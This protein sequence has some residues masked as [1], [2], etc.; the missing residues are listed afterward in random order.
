MQGQKLL[1]LHWHSFSRS[2]REHVTVS[3]AFK[4]SQYY[5]YASQRTSHFLIT[6]LTRLKI[7]DA[8]V[9]LIFRIGQRVCH[10]LFCI[11]IRPIP[12]VLS[13]ASNRH[14]HYPWCKSKHHWHAIDYHVQDGAGS[15]SLLFLVVKAADSSHKEQRHTKVNILRLA[16][17]YL[18]GTIHRKTPNT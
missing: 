11:E 12:H 3:L 2:G 8:P 6:L 13:S 14:L 10:F 5:R 17:G 7:I 4:G 16:V 1:T 15:V 18:D 9:L